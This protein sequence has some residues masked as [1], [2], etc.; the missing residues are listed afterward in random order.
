[1]SL[2]HIGNTTVRTPYR[3]R[4]ALIVLKNSEFCGSLLGQE[5]EAGFTE[6]LHEKSIVRVDRLDGSVKKPADDVGRKWRIALAQ[7]GF[8]VKHLGR[9]KEIQQRGIDHKIEP[10]T[11]GFPGLTGRPYEITPNGSRLI[12]AENIAAQQEC[13]LRALASYRIPSIFETDYKFPPFSPLRFVLEILLYLENSGE[14]AVIKLGEMAAIVQCSTPAH[15]IE[16]VVLEI[17]SYRKERDKSGN[18]KKFDDE[19]RID[20]VLVLEKSVKA[21]T[22]NDYADL[23]FRYLKATGLFQSKGRAIVLLPEK[24][25]LAELLT[26]EEFEIPDD[27]TYVKNLW[28]GAALPTDDRVKTLEILSRLTTQLK[29]HGEEIKEVDLTGMSLA[30]LTQ[31]RHSIEERLMHLKELYFAEG[32]AD[33]W[34]EI[35]NILSAFTGSKRKRVS[36]GEEAIKIQRGEHPAY[37]E[38]IIWRAFLA[39][40]SLENKPWES[41]RFKIDQDFLPL[42]HAPGGGPDMVFEFED[43]VLVVEVTLTSSSRQEAAEGETVRRHVAEIAE[44]FAGTGKRVYC[45]FIAPDIDSNTADTFKSGNWYKK[46]DTKLPLQIVPIALDGFITF[47]EAG[48]SA[49]DLKPPRIKE[50]IVE[51]RAVSNRDA[52][53]WKR[54]ISSEIKRLTSRFRQNKGA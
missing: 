12:T 54:E 46:D 45:M 32:Q 48:F 3:L 13:Y 21:G 49:G 2:W 17:L 11:T 35:I 7:L 15:G 44:R 53:E 25:T 51:C 39:V 16:K 6:L 19:K 41:R 23:N 14:E 47:L 34:H 8:I 20:A 9:P 33:L 29:G 4:E 31:R 30:E 28:K 22:L 27:S 18:K 43:F 42:S 36:R 26:S 1:M 52:P 37:F 10:F 40:D 5:R 50:L 24:Q 38:W